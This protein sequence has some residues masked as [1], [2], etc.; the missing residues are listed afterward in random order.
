MTVTTSLRVITHSPQPARGMSITLGHVEALTPTTI[1]H[2]LGSLDVLV[3]MTRF[4][5]K[6]SPTGREYEPCS[7]D[8]V[9]E[10]TINVTVQSAANVGELRALIIAV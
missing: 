6:Y 2:G 1:T 7:Y 4:H 10:N 9:D 3:S 5:S 8:V